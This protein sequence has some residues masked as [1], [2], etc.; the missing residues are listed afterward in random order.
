MQTLS[1]SRL[2]ST[3]LKTRANSTINSN[4]EDSPIP[5]DIVDLK[6]MQGLQ[7][8]QK[9]ESTSGLGKLEIINKK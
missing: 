1:G 4:L 2:G 7:S 5:I 3:N 6:I 8:T 9:I